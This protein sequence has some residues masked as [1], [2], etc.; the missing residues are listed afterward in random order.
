[1]SRKVLA[2]ASGKGGTG[3]TTVAVAM[4]QALAKRRAPVTLL[5]TDV[6]APNAHLFL[7]PVLDH[8]DPVVRIVPDLNETI[9]DGCGLCAE[10]CAFHAIAMLGPKPTVFPELCS[11]CGACSRLCPKQALRDVGHE[12]GRVE[13]GQ[14]GRI[15]FVHGVLNIGEAR[16]VPVITEVR[17]HEAEE[18]TTIID[19]P[20]GTSC[21]VI[22][23][24]RKADH[25]LL[26]TE[27]TR[28][29]L[30][31]LRLTVEMAQEL[32]LTMSVLINRV[33]AGSTDIEAWCSNES[34]PVVL[35]IPFERDIGAACARG[36]TLLDV[37]PRVADQLL[38]FVDSVRAEVQR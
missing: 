23:A 2:V 14:A 27:P 25:L 36:E 20:P 13:T 24:V 35:R 21:P 22:A 17:R 10:V 37:R 18:G 26:V 1:M 15:R 16:A 4:V 19:A 8:R 29:G 3:K 31:D 32:G 6:E 7:H 5:D 12:V 30:H 9:C 33:G 34:I 11:G 28:F 38:S